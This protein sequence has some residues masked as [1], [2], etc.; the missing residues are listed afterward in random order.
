MCNETEVTG[1]TQY[2]CDC[3]GDIRSVDGLNGSF[4]VKCGKHFDVDAP[5]ED[6]NSVE[7]PDIETI[8][9]YR[10]VQTNEIVFGT[11]GKGKIKICIPIFYSENQSKA[12]I[13]QQIRLLKY[14]KEKCK[15][16]GLDIESKR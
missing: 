4:C 14:T 1:T 7:I 12:I 6:T 9:A 2:R 15:S 13:D 3:G 16:E 5:K 10:G 11:E 8:K